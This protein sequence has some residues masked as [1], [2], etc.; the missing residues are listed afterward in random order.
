MTLDNVWTWDELAD[1]ASEILKEL[2]V[3]YDRVNHGPFMAENQALTWKVKDWLAAY[4]KAEAARKA[5]AS[6]G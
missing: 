3:Y 2:D 1:E 6:N 4:R 5:V